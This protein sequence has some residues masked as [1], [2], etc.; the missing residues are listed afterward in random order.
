M[1][2]LLDTHAFLWWLAGD[3]KLSRRARAAIAAPDEDVLVS[4][5]SAWEIATRHRLGK[6]PGVAGIVTDLA[7]AIASQAFTQ[8][9]ITI[10][11]AQRAGMLLGQHRDLFDRMLVAQARSEDLVLVSNEKVFD[12]FGVNR[13]W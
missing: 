4:A 7:A 11:H 13:L 9:P 3:A 5:A 1:A 8:L 2:L 12:S 10:V 6:L